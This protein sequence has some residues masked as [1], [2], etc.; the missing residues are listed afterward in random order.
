[1]DAVTIERTV[2]INL[3]Q[4]DAAR[5]PA[6]SAFAVN[7]G[8][9]DSFQVT[10]RVYDGAK[11]I[12]YAEFKSARLTLSQRNRAI[13]SAAVSLTGRDIYYTFKPDALG[14]PGQVFGELE[15]TGTDGSKL[16]TPYFS[17]FVTAS[18]AKLAEADRRVFIDE[19]ERLIN[20]IAAALRSANADSAEIAA[21]LED[22]R[23]K[24]VEAARALADTEESKRRAAALVAEIQKALD[25]AGVLLL[26][27]QADKTASG[28]VLNEA[29][30]I[31]ADLI[32]LFDDADGKHREMQGLLARAHDTSAAIDRAGD[33][34]ERAK[35]ALLADFN[36]LNEKAEAAEAA[37]EAGF[38][39]LAA[40]AEGAES[41][42]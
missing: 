25:A 14:Y 42:L 4:D 17:F 12:N 33:E 32:A 9:A 34:A 21:L 20:E 28:A 3:N 30:G 2:E 41:S 15:L 24:S 29:K 8:N 37:L 36:A 31:L 5:N 26:D 35:D 22:A 23:Q 40:N 10:F 38:N 18:L 19:V 11:E 39:T 13:F 27:I 7:Q 1:V 6:K 16:A